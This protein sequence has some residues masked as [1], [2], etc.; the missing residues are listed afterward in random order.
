V[1]QSVIQ[2]ATGEVRGYEALTR[3]HDRSS[4]ERRLAD[5]VAA[6]MG[7]PL[8]E[9]LLRAALSACD[10]LSDDQWLAVKAS[11]RLLVAEQRT[12][13]LIEQQDRIILV[14]VTEPSTSDLTPELRRLRTL[15]PANAGMVLEHARLG[16]KTLAALIALEPDYI[17]LDRSVVAGIAYDESRRTQVRSL[18]EAAAKHRSAVIA[19]GLES[20]ADRYALEL[21]GVELGQGFLLGSPGEMVRA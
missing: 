3:F 2:L 13:R 1:F 12:R 4:T 16:Y 9:V 11:P 7:M 21:L 5:A 19:A 18:V 10:E 6:G 8:E 15:L 20:A 17:K 14:E